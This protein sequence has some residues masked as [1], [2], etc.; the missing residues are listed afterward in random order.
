M[1][2][3]NLPLLFLLLVPFILFATLVLTNKE[4]IERVFSKKVLDRIKVEGN[5]LS[6]RV[7]NLIFFMAI[8]F[9][10][11]AIGHPYILKGEK[12]IELNGL[13]TIIALD[14][15]GSMRS[16]DRYPNRLEFAKVKT[17]EL[18]NNLVDDEVMVLTFSQDVYLVSPMTKDK[19]ILEQVVDGINSDYLQGGTNFTLLANIAKEKLKDKMQK[20]LIVVSDGGD[21]E[22]LDNFEDIIKKEGIKLYAIL[23]GTKEGATILDNKGKAI[24]QNDKIAISKINKKLGEIAINSGGDYIV[25]EYGK[26]DINKLSKKI[27]KNIKYSNNKKVIKVKDKI[28]L[29]YYPLILAT[30]LLIFAFSSIPT[31]KD[32]FDEVAKREVNNE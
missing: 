30:I 25:A 16:K 18:L 15:S 9:M 24:L 17:K 8:L 10:I 31:K 29:F 32:I 2:F 11:I 7:R 1:S 13:E 27:D 20:I 3:E 19:N 23:I 5:G 6:S 14:I 26:D 4:G 12:D 22:D 28:E 21:S